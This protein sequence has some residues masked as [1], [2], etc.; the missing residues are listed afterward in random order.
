MWSANDDSKARGAKRTQ[1][2]QSGSPNNGAK[3]IPGSLS[4]EEKFSAFSSVF[5]RQQELAAALD[6]S[7]KESGSGKTHIDVGQVQLGLPKSIYPTTLRPAELRMRGGEV[8]G[9]MRI[10]SGTLRSAELR[11]RVGEVAGFM[12]IG[13]GKGNARGAKGSGKSIY[14]D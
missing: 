3:G 13:S 1:E 2:T 4:P 6:S 8:A 5:Q 12:R 11:M 14:I 9:F 7:D 10:G